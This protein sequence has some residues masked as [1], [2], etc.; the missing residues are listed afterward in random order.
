MF[1]NNHSV[2][3]NRTPTPPVKNQLFY[4]LLFAVFPKAAVVYPIP[5]TF[6]PP[7]P[8]APEIH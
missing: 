5:C 4:S 1:K 8:N 2:K 6:S 7:P 3:N